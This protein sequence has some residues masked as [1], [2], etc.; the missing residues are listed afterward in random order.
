MSILRLLQGR[1]ISD[2][3]AQETQDSLSNAQEAIQNT[4]TIDKTTQYL[5]TEIIKRAATKRSVKKMPKSLIAL[6][7]YLASNN[8]LSTQPP[9]PAAGQTKSVV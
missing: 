5:R 3:M 7:T 9:S 2:K 4:L 8:V 6:A 1:K